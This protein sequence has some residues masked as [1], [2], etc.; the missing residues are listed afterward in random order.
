MANLRIYL[1]AIKEKGKYQLKLSDSDGNSGIDNLISKAKPNAKVKWE[2]KR[3]ADLK[4]TKI[5]K[6]GAKDGSDDIFGKTLKPVGR[7]WRGIVKADA[8]GKEEEYFIHYY[9]KGEDKEQV[10]DPLIRVPP[11]DENDGG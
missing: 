8:A 1:E 5:S 2:P 6:I 10:C 7:N 4:I 3:H 11:D 9:V